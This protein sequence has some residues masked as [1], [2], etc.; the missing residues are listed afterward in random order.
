MENA[1]D[2]SF[3]FTKKA[4]LLLE[5]DD[6][7]SL[8]DVKKRSGVSASHTFVALKQLEK[9]GFITIEKARVNLSKIK[10]TEF[11]RLVKEQMKLI[12]NELR[13]KQSSQ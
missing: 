3:F 12:V 1:K 13:E 11:G 5:L 8:A 2:F 10:L 6:G 9:M 4:R 7:M